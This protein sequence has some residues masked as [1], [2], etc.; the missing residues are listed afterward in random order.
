[1]QT[2]KKQLQR[3]SLM[4]LG[5]L[6]L[7]SLLPSAVSHADP[8]FNNDSFRAKWQRADKAVS[9]GLANPSR[10]WLWGPEGFNPPNAT[11]EPY[12]DSPSGSRQVLY[13]DKA[14]MEINNSNTGLVTNGLLVRELISG[15]LATGDSSFIQRRLPNDIPVAGDPTNNTGP[16]Y[17]SFYRVASLNN[18]NA[19]TPQIGEVVNQT[20]DQ[21]GTIGS[22]TSSGN[23]VKYA[24]FD[25]TL[26]HNIPDVFWYFMNQR[27]NIYQDGHYQN[28]QP[29]LG[30]NP[31]APWLETIGLPLTEAYWAKVTV[32]GQVKDVLIQAFERRVLTYTPSNPSAFQVEMG[33][34]GR[35][36]YTWRY[37]P[38]YDLPTTTLFTGVNL[39]GAEFA[40]YAIPGTF[41]LNYSYPTHAEI[42]YFMGKGM[43]TFRLPFL[44]E[45]LQ[46]VAMSD[47]K[48]DELAHIDDFVNYATGKG[49]A[50]VLDPHNYA[51]YYGKIV[52]QSEV[53]TVALADL[54]SRLAAHYKDNNRVIFGLMNEPNSISNQAWLTDV[55]AAIKAVRTTGANNLVL[56]PGSNTNS[57]YSWDLKWS[58]TDLGRTMLGVS[59]PANN[60]AYEYHQYLDADGS[61]TS[62]N[63]VS[64]TIGSQRL[65]D[66][67]AW[68]KQN[69]KRG[70]LGEFGGGRN[71]TCYKALD[72]MLTYID[73]NAEVWLGWT[74]WAAGPLWNEYI[75]TLEPNAS[76]DRPQLSVL[77]KHLAG[78]ST[79]PSTTALPPIAVL[80][81]T[82]SVST[83]PPLTPTP[84]SAPT[85]TVTPTPTAT[86]V[87]PAQSNKYAVQ[88]VVTSHWGTGYNISVTVVNDGSNTVNGWTISWQL[89]SDEMIANTWNANC[90]ISGNILTC[91]N[92]PY[93]SQLGANGGSQNFGLMFATKADVHTEPATFTVN[94]VKVN[95]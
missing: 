31:A 59:D 1:M 63:C 35:H 8:S 88:Y 21:A 13:F 43:N 36:Y 49:A 22:A 20:I 55:N 42:D 44:W 14:R 66:F 56:V 78:S 77:S 27:G 4:A 90:S 38:K 86:V 37:S 92:M 26:K 2:L 87:A 33:N 12:Q 5:L 61:G 18:D 53:P 6:V 40:P 9:E 47:L 11:T 64:P 25:S 85:A 50:V 71:D 73:H 30:D 81:V 62:G 82:A 70:F 79:A 34:V 91:T 60:Y 72:D 7:I 57:G 16:T 46:P 89:D 32:A 69:Q 28:N 23:Q 19:S 15:R 24:Y 67:T 83:Q 51:R 17:A 75:F 54:W 74:Y 65:Q 41:N 48:A 68:L 95:R 39:T 80:P 45:R 94:G 3:G 76:G 10:S 29:V 93:N 52:G 58:G 84:T